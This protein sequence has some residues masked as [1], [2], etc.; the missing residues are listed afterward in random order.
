DAAAAAESPHQYPQAGAAPTVYSLRSDPG[1]L[2]Q[3]GVPS[4]FVNPG[5]GLWP[6]LGG[7]ANYDG[8]SYPVYLDPTGVTTLGLTTL[9]LQSV[10]PTS[11]GIPR[12]TPSFVSTT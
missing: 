1:L 8:P 6:D 7:V 9:G 11:P 12:K 10:P 3:A 5:A 2:G 4:P